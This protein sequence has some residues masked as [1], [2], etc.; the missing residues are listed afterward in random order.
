MYK[1]IL[2]IQNHKNYTN[3]F[4]VPYF[5]NLCCHLQQE[6]KTVFKLDFKNYNFKFQIEFHYPFL[7]S[8]YL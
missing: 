6:P 5:N 1:Y 3:F 4:C 8:N 7:L 2:P